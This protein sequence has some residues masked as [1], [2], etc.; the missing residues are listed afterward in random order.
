MC[1]IEKAPFQTILKTNESIFFLARSDFP[2]SE[3]IF[4]I[5]NDNE[6]D[7]FLWTQFRDGCT[8]SFI[9][10]FRNYYSPLFNYGCKMTVNSSLAEDAIQDLFTDLWH[11]NGKANIVSLKAYLFKAF[12]FKLLKALQKAGKTN[13]FPD[14][15]QEHD[16][17][18]SHEMFMIT[19]ADNLE[20]FKKVNDAIKEL[21]PR[22]K[23]IIYLK[24]Q[25]NLSYEEI[26]EIMHINYQA[27]RNLLY[28]SIKVLKKIVL[29]QI[30]FLM[31]QLPKL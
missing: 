7:I 21:S 1:I 19:E 8:E 27:A 11:S 15:Y 23:E 3:E 4:M 20:L 22:Q 12:K 24:F 29:T 2:V 16:F 14:I 30:V 26:S 17:Q 9:K 10:I 5:K 13:S 6:E 31:A 25:Q 28:Q 18:L